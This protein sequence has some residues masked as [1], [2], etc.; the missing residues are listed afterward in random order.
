MNKLKMHLIQGDCLEILPKIESR[1]IDCIITDPPYFIGFKSS[2]VKEGT[3]SGRQD[4]GNHTMLTP[5]FDRIFK[6]YER[7]L[8]RNGR[9]FM[10]TDWRTYPTLYFSAAKFMR[11][12]NMIVWDYGWIKAGTQFR[13]THELILHTT[14]PETKSPK[15]RSLSDVWRIKPINFTQKRHHQ[16][17][18]PTA[19]IDVMLKNTTK[20]GDTI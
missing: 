20:E 11:I 13:F 16:A 19:V 8:K 9:V 5:L 10:F 6:E 17:E 4:W 2:A 15:N 3:T 18:K 7:I 1:S 12:S 14:M